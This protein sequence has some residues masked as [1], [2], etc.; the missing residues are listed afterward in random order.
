MGKECGMRGSVSNLKQ[1]FDWKM[2][3]KESIQKACVYMGG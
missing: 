2:W 3:R 1:N